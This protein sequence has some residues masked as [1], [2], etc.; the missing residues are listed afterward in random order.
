MSEFDKYESWISELAPLVGTPSFDTK[1]KQLTANMAR[2]EA[3]QL[4]M[5]IK[6]QAKPCLKVVDLRGKVDGQ[7]EPVE[8]NGRTHYLDP[9]A[10][11]LMAE[12]LA[13][14]NGNYVET[15]YDALHNTPNNYRVLRQREE[16]ER[17]QAALNKLSSYGANP[18]ISKGTNNDTATASHT[19]TQAPSEIKVKY[20]A[21]FSTF[22]NYKP[23]EHE[24]M[25]YVTKVTI[26]TGESQTSAMSVNISSQGLLVKLS[27]EV[28]YLTPGTEV[29]I[30]FVQL[31]QE[32][33]FNSEQNIAYKVVYHNPGTKDHAYGLQLLE[34]KTQEEFRGYVDKLILGNKFRY[35]IDTSNVE[36]AI[37]QRAYEYQTVATT[38]LLPIYYHNEQ[39]QIQLLYTLQNAKTRNMVDFLDIDKTSG[40][41]SIL[42]FERLAPVL[43]NE[44]AHALLLVFKTKNKWFAAF[45]HELS[46][47]LNAM[48]CYYARNQEQFRQYLVQCRQINGAEHNIPSI[49]HSSIS[50]E[51]KKRNTPISPRNEKKLNNI[52]GVLTLM[53]VTVDNWKHWPKAAGD[54]NQLKQFQVASV[55]SK[56]LQ[57]IPREFIDKRIDTRYPVKSNV[58]ITVGN[59]EYQAQSRDISLNGLQVACREPVD[60]KREQVIQANLVQLQGITKV[61]KLSRLEYK[62]VGISH[63]N[64][65][66]HMIVVPNA[67]GQHVGKLFFKELIKANKDKLKP[68][69]VGELQEISSGLTNLLIRYQMQAV[70]FFNAIGKKFQPAA[71]LSS[72]PEHPL[73]KYAKV[74]QDQ[75]VGHYVEMDRVLN[76][77]AMPLIHGKLK[78]DTEKPY[79]DVVVIDKGKDRPL[80]KTD[81][82]LG[83]DSAMRALAIKAKS[84]GFKVH[85]LRVAISSVLRFNPEVFRLELKYVKLYAPHRADHV[86]EHLNHL[87]GVGH[88]FDV[89]DLHMLRW[90]I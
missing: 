64:T 45:A 40:I 33:M 48:F 53:D 68:D 37:L 19:P 27:N 23:R 81:E 18:L 24:R 26:Y 43:R 15:I 79:L 67:N 51:I 70:S 16:E 50:K 25:L 30:D 56:H 85:I 84:A 4:K 73:L 20:I 2:S 38:N 74:Q 49:L 13:K 12:L 41:E 71:L 72:N 47:E 36:D 11:S 9:I 52:N 76:A 5:E 46:P 66:M 60:V 8:H 1:F 65:R 35:K 63:N 78:P 83:E 7:C 62:V 54:Y 69:D 75:E 80:I 86:L 6:R 14:F 3:F 17:K 29:H 32:V 22:L 58:V 88:I 59:Q 28:G 90:K 89:T 34:G 57:V 61:F 31:K 82:Q 42:T 44:Q 39:Q 87:K 77:A 10:A 55:G 21:K